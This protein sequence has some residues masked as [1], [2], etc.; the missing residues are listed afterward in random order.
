MQVCRACLCRC[1]SWLLDRRTVPD[2]IQRLRF[3]L[4]VSQSLDLPNVVCYLEIQPGLMAP[5]VE[6]ALPGGSLP[7]VLVFPAL[8]LAIKR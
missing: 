7:S 5:E 1:F 3:S 4:L 6:A 8:A 2:P